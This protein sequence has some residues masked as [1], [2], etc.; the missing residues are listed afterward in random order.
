M[1]S[2]AIECGA[3]SSDA[4]LVADDCSIQKH[5]RLGSANYQLMG[6]EKLEIFLQDIR[7][8]LLSFPIHSIGM[9]MPG[10]VDSTDVQVWKN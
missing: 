2:L 3:T 10:I 9:G 8:H 1:M 4:I 5:F 6:E 7:D